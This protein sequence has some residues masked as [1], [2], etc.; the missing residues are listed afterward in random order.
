VRFILAVINNELVVSNRRKTDIISDLRSQC[1]KTFSAGSKNIVE[2]ENDQDNQNEENDSGNGY[3][4]LLSM[5]IWSLSQ[6]RV[7]E[8]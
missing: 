6:E 1:F 5:K 7:R 3:D 8:K 4:Y 2:E